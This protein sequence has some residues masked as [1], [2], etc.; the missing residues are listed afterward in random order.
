MTRLYI[1]PFM[2]P[3]RPQSISP[4]SLGLI[5]I[6]FIVHRY[7]FYKGFTSSKPN[8]AQKGKGLLNWEAKVKRRA[9]RTATTMARNTKRFTHCIIE[10]AVVV[11]SCLCSDKP[12]LRQVLTE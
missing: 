7:F 2:R 4:F 11:L 10:M 6:L 1:S 5:L 3:K 12:F 9:G 8:R